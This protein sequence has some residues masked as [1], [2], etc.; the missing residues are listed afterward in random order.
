[1]T[2][3]AE[4]ARAGVLLSMALWY[5]RRGAVKSFVCRRRGAVLAARNAGVR[6]NG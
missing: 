4:V 3:V 5:N 1:M 2:F 6:T